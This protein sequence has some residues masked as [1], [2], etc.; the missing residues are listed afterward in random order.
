WTHNCNPAALSSLVYVNTAADGLRARGIE[1]QLEYLGN[2]RSLANLRRARARVRELSMAFD[3]VHAQYGSACALA[4]A[5]AR[6]PR[7]VSIRGNDWA[8]HS[9]SFGFSYVHTRLARAMTRRSLGRY[10]AVIAVS[11]RLAGEIAAFAPRAR[12][13]T[14]PSPVDLERFVPRDKAEARAALGHPGCTEK[15]V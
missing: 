5:A 14:L 11:N 9:E 8:V 1:P 6:I 12:V 3:L 15:W 4:T 13:A 7:V 10:D 2:L